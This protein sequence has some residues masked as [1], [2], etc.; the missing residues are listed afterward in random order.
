MLTFKIQSLTPLLRGTFLA[1][2]L[3]GCA[4]NTVSL[5]PENIRQTNLED[6]SKAL[7]KVPPITQ[8]LTL[9]NA[10]ARG[11]KFNLEHQLKTFEQSLAVS[12]WE[13]G[14]FDMLP[15]LLADTGYDWRNNFSQRFQSPANS[16]NTIDKSSPSV[17]SVDPSHNTQ[18]LR[19]SWNILD[20]GL[21]YYKAKQNADRILIASENRRKAGLILIQKIRTAYWRAMS[22]QTLK[23]SVKEVIA[24]S[25]QALKQSEE[26][27]AE[28]VQQPEEKLRYQRNLLE[29][30]RLLESVEREL[31]SARVE[32]CE[33]IG[34]TP[35]TEFTLVNP[36]KHIEPLQL[37]I[38]QLESFALLNNTDL[39]EQ[40]L[41][42]RIA[43]EE[44]KKAFISQFPGLSLVYGGYRDSD[45]YLVESSWTAASVNLSYNLLGLLNASHRVG[46]SEK[47]EEL[48][49]RRRMTI[50]MSTL[51]KLHLAAHQYRDAYRQYVLADRIHGVDVGLRK[52]A[53]A[54]F[55]TK[56]ASEQTLIASRVTEILSQLR[57]F[58]AMSRLEE[59]VGQLH[60]SLGLDPKVPD[61]DAVDLKD[62]ASLTERWMKSDLAELVK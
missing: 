42:V 1:V 45:R 53:Q 9:Y 30:L 55:E 48:A 19:L 7:N 34:V 61:L 57:R 28:L 54:R 5:K 16:P 10:I 4:V 52:I 58:Q 59:T 18:S 60:T 56:M 35:D 33:L 39:K 62:L 47:A 15:K 44:T 22:A 21:S 2:C 17:V 13:D 24:Q 40:H 26:L 31:A 50:Q 11:L 3:T 41:N 25:E 43:Q 38:E 49:K 51:V 32:L 46:T 29:N 8:D 36:D 12:D 14:K 27:S 6:R 37:P 23:Q 20:F